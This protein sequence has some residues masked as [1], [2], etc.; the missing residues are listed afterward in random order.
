MQTALKPPQSSSSKD[1]GPLSTRNGSIVAA[2][3]AAAVAGLLIVFFLQQY[4]DNVNEESIPTAVVVADQ[5]IEQGASGDTVGAQGLFKIAKVPRDQLKLGAVT[6]AAALRG[7]IAVADILPG[8]QLTAAD[9]KPAGGG[10]ITKLAADQ[11]AISIPLD[12][13][14]GLVGTLVAGDHVDVLSGFTLGGGAG[15]E[16]PVLRMLMQDVLVLAVPAAAAGG[17]PGGGGANANSGITLRVATKAAPKLAFAADNSRL[18][19]VLRP[20]NGEKVER[21]PVVSLQSLVGDA[22]KGKP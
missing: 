22:G 14:H 1:G 11:R 3:V 2:A 4:R 9:F 8:Q 6:D 5:L 18:W 20:Q 12:S 19:L 13:T 7:K 10:V 21:T 16:R 17:G 15:G